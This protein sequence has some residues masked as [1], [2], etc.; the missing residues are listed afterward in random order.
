MAGR[1]PLA[2][3]DLRGNEAAYLAR[4]VTDNWVSS[5]GPEV[6]KL[7]ATVAN[8]SGR[9]HGVTTVNGTA[10]LHLALL[11]AGVGPGDRVIVP[12]RTFAATANAFL[13]P[14]ACRR[15]PTVDHRRPQFPET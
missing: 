7:E 2:I 8:L 9:A 11:A 10:A 1:I 14:V 12:D 5:A 4:C 15:R 13:M 6:G 3:P